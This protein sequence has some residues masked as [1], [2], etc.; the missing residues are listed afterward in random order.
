MVYLGVLL[1]FG[2]TLLWLILQELRRNTAQ[3]EKVRL[4][5][6]HF[7]RI[8]YEYGPKGRGDKRS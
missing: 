3:A 6:E 1:L 7:H 4:Q 8:W 5:I 2:N